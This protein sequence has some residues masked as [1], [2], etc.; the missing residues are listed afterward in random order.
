MRFWDDSGISLTMCKQSAPR[1][2]LIT[3][4]TN[5][6]SVNLYRPAAF[7]D[8]QPTVSKHWRQQEKRHENP[9]NVDKDTEKSKLAPFLSVAVSR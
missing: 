9:L 1:S 5:T 2:R 8:A 3:N 7:P 6:S 4:H